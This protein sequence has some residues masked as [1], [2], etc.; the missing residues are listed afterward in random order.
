MT[1]LDESL[2][3]LLL[4]PAVLVPACALLAMSASARLS[5]I[6]ARV[7]DLHQRRLD[8]Y[9]AV[10]L[11]DERALQVREIRLD[12]LEVQSHQLIRRAALARASL[13]LTYLSVAF[14][15]LSSG[16]L[17]LA[18][19]WHPAEYVA[20]T[21]FIVGLIVVLA[22]VVVAI[23]DVRGALRWVR[24]EHQRVGSLGDAWVPHR[25]TDDSRLGHTHD[26]LA[27]SSSIDAAPA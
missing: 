14:L 3:E 18:I 7:R 4:A 21:L 10:P 22:A 19:V 11:D 1:L 15:L 26:I 6:L 27:D 5:S 8:A 20:I 24:Y 13:I 9:V 12:G 23:L 17:G 16:S 2:I 25:A